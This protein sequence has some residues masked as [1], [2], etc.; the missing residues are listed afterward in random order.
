VGQELSEQL[1]HQ[2]PTGELEIWIGPIFC[3]H[4]PGQAIGDKAFLGR[5]HTVFVVFTVKEIF[6]Q[7][8]AAVPEKLMTSLSKIL[9]PKVLGHLFNTSKSAQVQEPH[10]WIWPVVL[11]LKIKSS[12]TRCFGGRCW[13]VATKARRMLRLRIANSDGSTL[14]AAL[15]CL[16]SVQANVPENI[17]SVRRQANRPALFDG[18]SPTRALMQ[19]IEAKVG[20]NPVQPGFN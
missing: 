4:V 3:S 20:R 8:F 11:P 7:A 2:T 17:V 1:V 14:K 6:V 15:S 18:P 9:F 19:L 10:L 16:K 12:T 13:S 5:D